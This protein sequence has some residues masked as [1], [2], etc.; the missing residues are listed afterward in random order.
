MIVPRGSAVG[1]FIPG[2]ARARRRGLGWRPAWVGQGLGQI[3]PV[4]Y[5]D[6]NSFQNA[7]AASFP[8]CPPP[9]DPACEGPRSAAIS[10][11]LASWTS[12][13]MSCHN[14]VCDVSGSPAVSVQ[15]Y[16]TPAGTA[17]IGTGYNTVSGFVPTVTVQPAPAPVSAPLSAPAAAAAPV[18]ARPTRPAP[19]QSASPAAAPGGVLAPATAPTPVQTQ[20]PPGTVSNGSTPGTA[21]PIDM[22]A[23]GPAVPDFGSILASIPLWGWGVAAVG[24]I[25]ITRGGK[26]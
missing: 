19:I 26:R 4:G 3:S 8:A 6:F 7:V 10:A 25:L 2:R 23:T 13:P 24:L 9:Y 5:A 1:L 15:E 12:D 17:A 18:P 20:T 21:I 11:D 14:V 16:T 22:G